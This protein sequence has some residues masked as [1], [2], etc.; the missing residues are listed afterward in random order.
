MIRG[1]A[2]DGHTVA[3]VSGADGHESDA[4]TVRPPVTRT[5]APS[6]EMKSRWFQCCHRLDA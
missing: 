1:A 4:R 5:D 6:S 2:A 3:R